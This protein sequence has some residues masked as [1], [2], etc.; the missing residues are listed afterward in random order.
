MRSV[1]R[2]QLDLVR[3]LTHRGRRTEQC[4]HTFDPAPFTHVARELPKSRFFQS[5]FSCHAQVLEIHRLRQKVLGAALQRLYRERNVSVPRDHDDDRLVGANALEHIEAAHVRK[6]Q[7][8][9]NEIGTR[10]LIRFDAV[11]ATVHAHHLMSRAL[12]KGAE[13]RG[14]LRRV[15]DDEDRRH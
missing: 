12:E 7:I 1:G 10:A 5:A 8:E 3:E 2:E 14:D 11:L 9:Q 6:L 13:Y 4:T 15:V